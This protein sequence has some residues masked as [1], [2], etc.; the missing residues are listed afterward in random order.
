MTE[1]PVLFVEDSIGES[2]AALFDR[3]QALALFL[4]R[5]SD[6][7]RCVL[8]DEVYAGRL[9]SLD[10]VRG[11]GFVD[12]GTGPEGYWPYSERTPK[13]AQGAI[14]PWKIQT[15]A[16]GEKGP[17]ISL[18]T[19]FSSPL[20]D[21]PQRLHPAPPLTEF[22]YKGK[23]VKTLY[24]DS[25]ETRQ[26][27][28]THQDLDAVFAESLS[29]CLSLSSGARLWIETTQA[30]TVFDV[31]VG[32]SF[33]PAFS[34]AAMRANLAAAQE[35]V[36][37]IRRRDLGGLMAFDFINVKRHAERGELEKALKGFFR[38]DAE[39]FPG[40]HRRMEFA[41][42]SR[43]CVAEFTR[44]R[45]A[46]SL[47]ERLLGVGGEKTSETIALEA[48]RLLLRTGR[49]SPGAQLVLR[50]APRAGI[51]L[52]KDIIPWRAG[53]TERLGGPFFS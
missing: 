35:A 39:K 5:W 10:S 48:L 16:R 45:R 25:P 17:V 50:L 44:Q 24:T 32:S 36:C 6:E 38:K 18:V 43:F 11:G 3:G 46:L 15:E 52:D 12:L 40:D 1:A 37:Q 53:L 9:L 29:P 4:K 21:K 7:G 19:D 30:M 13:P 33:A 2:R 51:W 41:P 22:L 20:P 47:P 8:C 49:T 26:Y 31:D 34:R 23:T 14:L 42:L 28:L 27:G